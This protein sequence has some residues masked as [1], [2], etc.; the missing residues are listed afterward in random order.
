[1]V[2]QANSIAIFPF[3][4]PMYAGVPCVII[5]RDSYMDGLIQ[6]HVPDY[7]LWRAD[8]SLDFARPRQ[9]KTTHE[10]IRQNPQLQ[11]LI[12]LLTDMQDENAIEDAV[13]ET[14]TKQ[15]SMRACVHCPRYTV[16]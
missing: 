9:W 15:G 1:M 5:F 12:Y 10:A 16:D 13:S 2:S 14:F 4:L 7:A 11:Q 8:A 3:N 6:E